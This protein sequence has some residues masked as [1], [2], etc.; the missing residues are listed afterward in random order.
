MPMGILDT[1][2][3]WGKVFLPDDPS[4]VSSQVH[5]LNSPILQFSIR[6]YITPADIMLLRKEASLMATMNL[7][8]CWQV[9]THR[10]IMIRF[11]IYKIN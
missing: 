1:T 4:L 5:P 2:R 9:V 8:H 6:V 10:V 7:E 3:E 11:Y